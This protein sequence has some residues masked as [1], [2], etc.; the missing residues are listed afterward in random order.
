VNYKRERKGRA[1][2]GG[3]EIFVP[4]K[5]ASQP[6]KLVDKQRTRYRF[7]RCLGGNRALDGASGDLAL[8]RSPGC[9]SWLSV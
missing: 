7:T 9:V 2:P 4:H 5:E 3:P 1:D 6:E 8:F